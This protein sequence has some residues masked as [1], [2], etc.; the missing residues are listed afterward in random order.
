MSSI[1]GF[2]NAP[3]DLFQSSTTQGTDL[4]GFATTNDGRSF[5]Y[6]KVGATALVPGTLVQASA[7]DTSNLQGLSVTAAA[8]G[9]KQIT[10]SGAPAV[11]ANALAGGFVATTTAAGY[12]YSYKIS[13]NSVGS[14]SSSLVI[15]LEDPIVVALTTASVV[16]LIPSPF[17]GVVVNPA[18]ATSS[19]VGAAVSAIPASNYGWVQTHGACPITASAAL[20]VGKPVAASG[21]AGNV[22]LATSVVTTAVV[23]IAV[24]GVAANET[25]LVFLEID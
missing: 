2:N 14:A 22:V 1:K 13:S 5:R 7:E 24:T 6:V 11:T 18:T 16:D 21:V 23:G 10:I 15:T 8:A 12:G 17:S 20:T 9:V 3:Q 4:G 19:I 25:G